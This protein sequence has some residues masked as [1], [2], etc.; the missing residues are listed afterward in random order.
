MP[1]KYSTSRTRQQ[2][3]GRI[4]GAAGEQG[5][6]AGLRSYRERLTAERAALDQ[7]LSAIDQALSVLG[8]AAPARARAARGAMGRGVVARGGRRPAGGSLRE[9]ID[10]VLRANGG[11][12]AVKDITEAVR[13]AGYPTRNQTLAKSVGVTLRRMNNIV[14][15]GRGRFRM[16]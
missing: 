8:A 6:L 11:V 2:R 9:Y 1:R 5:A 14:K 7:K 12:M 3:G 15:V 10:R 4:G 16:K 13:R